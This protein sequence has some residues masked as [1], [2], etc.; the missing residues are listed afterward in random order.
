MQDT[1]QKDEKGFT[2]IEIIVTIVF[3]A[4]VS[5]PLLMYFTD[6]VRH[7]SRTKQEQNAVVVAQDTLEELKNADYNLDTPAGATTASALYPSSEPWK[8]LGAEP[9]P[10]ATAEGGLPIYNS[11]YDL[12]R[13]AKTN[14]TAYKVK[15]HIQPIHE[16][17]NSLSG[18]PTT[19]SYKEIDTSAIAMDSTKDVI[20]KETSTHITNAKG[21]F[22]G[23]H[24]ASGSIDPVVTA[25][26]IADRLV[27]TIQIC[28]EPDASE[29]DHILTTVRYLSL[30]HI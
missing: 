8:V 25:D 5:L 22:F 14:G 15:A 21:Y 20:S 9:A 29:A 12:W 10:D 6:S 11:G 23:L 16:V 26:Y 4:L 2:L 24:A 27:R 3:L 30:I 13:K 19:E 28:L 17:T 1:L 7:S 18:S